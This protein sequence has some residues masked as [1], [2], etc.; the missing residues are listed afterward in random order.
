MGL[1]PAAGVLAILGAS[2]LPYVNWRTVT[3][4]VDNRPLLIRQDAKGDGRFRA[5]RSGGRLHRG[6]DLVAPL[7]SPVRAIRSGRVVTTAT[8]RGLGRY[9]E[10]AHDRHLHSLYAHLATIDVKAGQR[11][12]QG[13]LLGTVGK[14]G[15]ARH[16][17]ITP[18]LHVEIL[19]DGEPMDPARLG[20]A[21]V[22]PASPKRTEGA[23]EAGAQAD[24]HDDAAE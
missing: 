22:E 16:A 24:E 14:T 23:P 11:V 6:V 18:H 10:I 2:E 12:R 1:L 17:W 15:N 3:P 4:P 5:P 8:H 21:L 20:L 9:V 13:D 7:R 19:K